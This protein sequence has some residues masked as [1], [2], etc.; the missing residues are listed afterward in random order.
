MP[1]RIAAR[2]LGLAFATLLAIARPAPVVAAQAAQHVRLVNEGSSGPL[3]ECNATACARAQTDN[4]SRKN[5]GEMDFYVL[6]DGCVALA[7]AVLRPDGPG[8]YVECGPSG[9]TMWHICEGGS[10]R[11]LDSAA[12]AASATTRLIPLPADC[13]GRIHEII[14]VGAPTASPAFFIEC[15][16]SSGPRREP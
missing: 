14:V 10:C 9:K 5:L 2:A 12:G 6:P 16:A 7:R 1:T 4:P 3:Y 11:P 13:G 8:I 15:D